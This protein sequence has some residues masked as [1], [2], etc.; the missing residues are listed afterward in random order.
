MITISDILYLLCSELEETTPNN[1]EKIAYRKFLFSAIGHIDNKFRVS[2]NIDIDIL[3]IS[4][5]VDIIKLR[6]EIENLTILVDSKYREIL[7]T[8]IY[9]FNATYNQAVIDLKKSEDYLTFLVSLQ[10]K[11][12]TIKKEY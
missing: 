11:I 10:H 2:G 4:I 1:P 7:K 3:T 5:S 8:K 12:L 6:K 9:S